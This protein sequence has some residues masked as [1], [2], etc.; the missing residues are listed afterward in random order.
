MDVDSRKSLDQDISET[1][2]VKRTETPRQ[3]V[4]R[5]TQPT[6]LL[7]EMKSKIH[8]VAEEETQGKKHFSAFPSSLFTRYRHLSDRAHCIV[9]GPDSF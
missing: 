6:A 9:N 5:N 7:C 2:D 1:P 4:K 3:T 8:K